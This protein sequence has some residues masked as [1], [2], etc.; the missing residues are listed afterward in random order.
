MISVLMHVSEQQ[1]KS[2][3]VTTISHRRLSPQIAQE[4]QPPV[5]GGQIICQ[6]YKPYN[7]SNIRIAIVIT[8][9]H[10]WTTHPLMDSWQVD[11]A[12][13]SVAYITL[14]SLISVL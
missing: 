9:V 14:E 7:L 13:S 1:Y 8:S 11:L 10:A 5:G 2:R 12:I 3:L 4:R 6:Q